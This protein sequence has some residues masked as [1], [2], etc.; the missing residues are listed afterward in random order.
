MSDDEVKKLKQI[1][2]QLEGELQNKNSEVMVYRQEL[3]KFSRQLDHLMSGVSTDLKYLSEMQKTLAPTELPD[4]PGFEIS[5]KF[6]YGSKSGGDFFDFFEFE[7]KFRFGLLVA[8]SSGY[9]M[10]ALFLSFILKFSH[11]LQAKKGIPPE[12]ILQKV[13][14]ELKPAAGPNDLTHAFYAVIDRRDYSLK[15][16]SVGKIL[17]FYL[18]PNL[19]VQ[20]LKSSASP[21]GQ[22][23]G[24]VLNSAQIELE[25]RSRFCV[26]TDG[27]SDILRVELIAKIL[28]E[29]SKSSVHEIR[30]ELL[31]QAARISKTP[32]PLRDQT[33]VVIDVKDRVIKL[34]KS[35]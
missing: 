17:G 34:A 13:A 15:F 22:Q 7:D 12:Q 14:D 9:A 23:F 10:S 30:N 18:A 31:F 4:I 33:V 24:E 35:T 28:T 8:S 16:C 19:S 11:I 3:T 26:M 20:V 27:L 2:T 29:N 1:I 6:V 5:R 32:E 21:F 25:P